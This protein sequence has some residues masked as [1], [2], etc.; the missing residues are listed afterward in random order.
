MTFDRPLARGLASV[1]SRSF[2]ESQVP[3][4]TSNDQLL[5]YQVSLAYKYGLAT[6]FDQV[7]QQ[8]RYSSQAE[9][10]RT[11]L[12]ES[13]SNTTMLASLTITKHD[14]SSKPQ[15]VA[16]KVE[17]TVTLSALR[18]IAQSQSITSPR[19]LF[20]VTSSG[21]SL[22]KAREERLIWTDIQDPEVSIPRSLAT[23]GSMTRFVFRL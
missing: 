12:L 16:V 14:G 19:D 6:L 3:I 5:G 18:G 1:F 15:T 20:K 22:P 21:I 4:E 17:D 8:L 2:S 7:S 10:Q 13:H 11:S 9:F 23:C